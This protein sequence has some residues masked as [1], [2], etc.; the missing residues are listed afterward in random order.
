MKPHL[1]RAIAFALSCWAAAGSA[2]TE[3]QVT[4]PLEYWA[5]RDVISNVRLSP[6]GKRLAL[7]KIPSRDGNPIVE[8]YDAA[9]L[10]KKPLRLDAKP[11]EII[12][13]GFGWLNDRYMIFRA[14]QKVRD[15]VEFFNQD[16][17]KYKTVLL[18]VERKKLD[19]MR[20]LGERGRIVNVLP[21]DPDKVLVVIP[22]PDANRV[23]ARLRRAGRFQPSDYYEYDLAKRTKKLVLQGKIA[24]G[25]FRFD[26]N[27]NPQFAR[28]YNAANREAVWYWRGAG[29]TSWQEYRRAPSDDLEFQPF[30]TIGMDDAEPNHALVLA[31]NGYDTIG[32]WSYDLEKKAFS[33]LI[34]RHA[35]VDVLNEISHSNRWA[36]PDKIVGLRYILDKPRRQYLADDDGEG[37]TYA[38]LEGLI[39]HAYAV[40]IT[41]RS[42]DGA[43]MVI[44]NVGPQDPGTYYLLK[45][46][47]VQTIGSQQPLLESENLAAMEYVRFKS[48]DGIDISAY[49]TV[50]KGEPP[51]PLVVVPHGGPFVQDFPTYDKW[52]QLLANHGYLVVQPQYRGSTGFGLKHYQAAFED[53]GQQGRKMQDDKDDAA[54][55]LVEQGLADPDRMAMFGWSYGGY[56]AAVAASRT[57]QIYQCVV[58]GAAV[59]DPM[60]Q[61]NEYRWR[62]EGEMRKRHVTFDQTAVSPVKEVAN[63][64]VPML[65]VHGDVDA[66]VRIEH[67]KKYLD[68][69]D[70]EGKD[71]RY[72][73]LEGAAHFYNTL[74]Y[75]HN[76]EFFQTMI[77]FLAKD[78]GPDGL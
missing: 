29:D 22:P 14:R 58:A 63:I 37:A 8:I 39:P 70:G 36:Q 78:C 31:R 4:Y 33:E 21:N 40:S 25:A 5:M 3:A 54:L 9:D 43:S 67:A 56:A 47:K 27:G 30:F 55:Y 53:G 48:R 75:D 12:T 65:V 49:V 50:P 74:F 24:L 57:P 38:Q 13:S 35:E 18:D 69:L 28:G 52:V 23:S 15:L 60:M 45:D 68:A 42:R 6:D 16:V 7:L 62:L 1:L 76:I 66:R 2:A 77:D 11:M 26:A 44:S 59:L 32:L 61:I 64:N 19:E 72:L 20:Q 46:G 10:D 71:V 34:F 73:E 51:F 17:Y 41:S